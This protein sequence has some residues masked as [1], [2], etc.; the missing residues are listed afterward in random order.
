MNHHDTNKRPQVAV[1]ILNWN[2]EK[3]LREFLPE[4]IA[5]TD[6]T[7]ARVIVAD[8]G[9]TDG[10]RR[11]L[12]SEFADVEHIY[13]DTNHGFAGGYNLAIDLTDYRYTVLLNSDVATSAGWINT[14][15]QF[16]EEHPEVGACQPK[17]LSF[18]DTQKF[19]YAGAA[20]GF[21]DRNGYPFCRG[22]IFG[23][24][25]TDDGQYD[26]D[27]EIFWASGAC[28]MVRS[29]LY[30]KVGGLDTAFFAHME[31]IDLCWRIMLA[32]YKIMAV[33]DTSVFHLGG[34]SL[35]DTNPRKT[36]LNFRN[37]LLM[38]HKNLPDSVRS[39]KLLWRRL[40]DTIAWAKYIATLKFKF[41]VA[42][43][44]AH[45]DFARMRKSYITHPNIN[46]L[47]ARPDCHINILTAYYLRGRKRFSQLKDR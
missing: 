20:G 1:I 5:T 30:R 38:L 16:M 10:S 26:S 40:L 46:L 9:S 8:N 45:R 11:L 3:L 41:A 28:L 29:E 15:Y 23:T 19:E 37:N 47:A 17:L 31:E 14:L 24:C 2:G 4:V 22:R 25:E 36:Y 35:P 32:G 33:C 34:G 18:N 42:I 7:I 43:V 12:E 27:I 39:R 6:P 13:F 44:K 21:I